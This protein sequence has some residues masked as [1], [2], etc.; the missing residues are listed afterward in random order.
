M[1]R[2][3]RPEDFRVE[4]LALYPPTGEGGHTFLRIEKRLR[5]TAEVAGELARAVGVRPAEVGYAGR[6]DRM[7]ISS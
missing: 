4:E 6:K 3:E 5:T 2:F 1:I 7:S